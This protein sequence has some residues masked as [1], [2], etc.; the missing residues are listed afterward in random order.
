MGVNERR[1]RQRPASGHRP[2]GHPEEWEPSCGEARALNLGGYNLA[3]CCSDSGGMRMSSKNPRETGRQAG[4]N[5]SRQAS[6]ES[7]LPGDP[8]STSEPHTSVWPEQP[9]KLKVGQPRTTRASG[10]GH[11]RQLRCLPQGVSASWPRPRAGQGPHCYRTDGRAPPQEGSAH[12]GG[13][14]PDHLERVRELSGVPL[15]SQGY[16]GVERGF[17]GH[18]RDWC[19]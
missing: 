1:G 4:D 17:S 13:R 19:N 6:P 12:L 5:V 11:L 10:L 16:C 9:P 7:V 8:S 18:H 2:Q 15:R 14:S 3:G